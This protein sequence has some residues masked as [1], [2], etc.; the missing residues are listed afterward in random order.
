MP[1]LSKNAMWEAFGLRALAYTYYGGA[2][3][4]ECFAT[5]EKLQTT[6]AW[7]SELQNYVQIYQARDGGW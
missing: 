6:Q 2:D 1:V 5:I 3:L 7:F 4:G